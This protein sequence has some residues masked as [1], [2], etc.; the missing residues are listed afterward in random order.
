LFVIIS[1]VQGS[2][3]DRGLKGKANPFIFGRFGYLELK[4]QQQ[5][6]ILEGDTHITRDLGI[7]KGLP[8]THIAHTVTCMARWLAQ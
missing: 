2:Q 4:K 7:P 5:P 3:I 6:I 8:V 1:L